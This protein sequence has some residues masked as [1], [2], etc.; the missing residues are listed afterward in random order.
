MSAKKRTS[1]KPTK[2]A[3][4]RPKSKR[5]TKA[6]LEEISAVLQKHNWSAVRILPVSTQ[7]IA[8]SL[9][10]VADPDCGLKPTPE[11]LNCAAGQEPTHVCVTCNG[12]IVC[13]WKCV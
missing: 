1:K 10:A 7:N 12:I 11:S 4:K 13:G 5:P 9:E 6:M 2:R 3:S 8:A